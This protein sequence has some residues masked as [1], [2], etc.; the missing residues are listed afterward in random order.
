[1]LFTNSND[2]VNHVKSKM[3]S[4]NESYSEI[5][6]YSLD[7]IIG[8]ERPTM[9]K[10]DVEGFEKE[11][12]NGFKNKLLDTELNAILI[13]LNGCGSNYGYDDDDINSIILKYGFKSYL[14]N[15]YTRK[16]T[17]SKY[18]KFENTLY[19]RNLNFVEDRL[20]K[21]KKFNVLGSRI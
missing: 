5:Q 10:I 19:I 20:K 3:D 21:A 8:K 4:K 18:S 16:L 6:T 9:I 17:P 1:M 2:S 7:E 11:V 12:I 15:P 14:Y 13:E